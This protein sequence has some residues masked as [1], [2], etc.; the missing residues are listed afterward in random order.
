MLMFLYKSA[1]TLTSPFI[2][3][4][5][6]HREKKGK[7]IKDRLPERYGIASVQRPDAPLIWVHGA[8]VGESLSALK[9]INQL[10]SNNPHLHVLMT[11]GTVTSSQILKDKLGK[12]VVHQFMPLDHPKWV[13]RFLDYWKPDGMIWLESEIWPVLFREAER[14]DIPACLI[15]ARLS[16]KSF[17]HW[18]KVNGFIK[19]SLSLFKLCLTQSSWDTERYKMLGLTIART[20]GNLK[21]TSNPLLVD[22][23]M[24][25]KLEKQCDGREICLMAS[26]HE[27]EEEVAIAAYKALKKTYPSL[28]FILAPR[29]PR[30]ADYVKKLCE[31]AGL[32]V[33]MHSVNI[34]EMTAI[35]DDIYLVDKIGEMG[36]FYSLSPVTVMGGSFAQKGGHNPIEPA[37]LGSAI[38]MGPHF[39]NFR[40]ICNDFR[41]AKAMDF[42]QDQNELVNKISSLLKNKEKQRKSCE[43]AFKLVSEKATLLDDT[44]SE[45]VSFLNK[46]SQ[47]LK[48]S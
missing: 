17:K 10:I 8:S 22:Q 2:P 18:R 30:R 11:S 47:N 5:L 28:L 36:L 26:S 27:G 16:G 24:L 13:T 6:E 46:Y 41:N 29:H 21:Y 25:K 20:F 34:P 9:L 7:E 12:Q 23:K 38:I 45:I 19:R 15:N 44:V 37:Q 31:N 40:E 39:F 48:L 43:N 14:R 42:V 33:K 4:Y 3:F 1:W 32:T 35:A